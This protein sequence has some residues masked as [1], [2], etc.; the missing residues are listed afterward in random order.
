MFSVA[1]IGPDGAGKSTL[2][3][4]L[5]RSFP[6]PVRRLYMGI[7]L[8][9]SNVSLPTSRLAAA[10]KGRLQRRSSGK[11][12]GSFAAVDS[13]AKTKGTFWRMARLLNRL[14]E[15]WYRQFLSWKYR[16]QGYVVVYDR[17]FQFDFEL[18]ASPQARSLSDRLH[19]WLLAHCYPSPDL[20][21]YLDAPAE[22]LFAR[23]GE[24][25]VEWLEQRRHAFSRQGQQKANFIRVD[26]V[27][28]L[29]A[30]YRE[31]STYILNHARAKWHGRLKPQ[32][33][34]DSAHSR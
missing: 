8:E 21:I 1:L 4:Q 29:D 31:V 24:A 32:T 25:S 33:Q 17:H 30:V 16:A 12:I 22:V 34:A 3:E 5:E 15:E 9:S 7:S 14:A 13:S 26:A 2:A 20:V 27:Q 10:I 18:E 28:P 6:L 23:K 11:Q 19:R